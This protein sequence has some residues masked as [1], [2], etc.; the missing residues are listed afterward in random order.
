MYARKSYCQ[1]LFC[2]AV[3]LFNLTI[4]AYVIACA[5]SLI[6]AHVLIAFWPASFANKTV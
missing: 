5:H 4:I 3:P 6:F 2:F 1:L